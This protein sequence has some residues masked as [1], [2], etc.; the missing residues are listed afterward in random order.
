MS[1]V[2]GLDL[3]RRQITYDVLDVESG[4][5]WRGRLSQPDRSRFRYWLEQDVTVRA[6][7]GAVALA[8]EGCTG[9]RYVTEEISAAGFTPFLAEPADTQAARGRRSARR[10]TAPMRGCYASSCN[11]A[12]FPRAGSHPK[13]SSSGAIASASTSPWSTNARFGASASTRPST[14]TA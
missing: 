3:H 6:H 4:E 2:G 10:P 12:S 7:N 1:M 14:T 8:V 9:W 5:I 13:G 11:Q